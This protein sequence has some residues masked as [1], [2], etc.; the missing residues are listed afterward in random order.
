MKNNFV[1]FLSLLCSS[2]WGQG[3][4]S[5][6]YEKKL[7]VKSSYVLFLGKSF[8]YYHQDSSQNILDYATM[9][10]V[11]HDNGTY[12][13]YIE[14]TLDF[15]GEWSLNAAKD[16]IIFEG[17]AAVLTQLDAENLVYRT[18]TLQF[19]DTSARLD[20]MYTFTHLVPAPVITSVDDHQHNSA[21][22]LFPNPVKNVLTIEVPASVDQE[23]TLRMV[24][25]YGQILR[26]ESLSAAKDRFLHWDV[27]SLQKGMY[28]MQIL[29]DGRKRYAQIL[30]KE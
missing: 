26:E 12:S 6:L 20:T 29:V 16:R 28:Y 2:L 10:F 15:K 14:D 4:P 13:G 19:A 24:N 11:F 5:T 9:S 21:I 1:I 8:T 22:H 3:L 30:M 17:K 25:A 27:Q 18:H 7:I 23:G